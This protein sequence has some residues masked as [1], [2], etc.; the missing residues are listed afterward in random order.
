MAGPAQTKNDFLLMNGKSQLV[1]LYA[2]HFG[3]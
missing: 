3:V 2:K 1:K